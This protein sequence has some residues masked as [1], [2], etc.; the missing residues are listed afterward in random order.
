MHISSPICVFS[1]HIT[2]FGEIQS[3]YSLMCE[4]STYSQATA[5]F[6]LT[7]D[8]RGQSFKIGSNRGQPHSA[9]ILAFP[10]KS[11]ISPENAEKDADFNRNLR[12]SG[13]DWET[14]TLDLMRVKHAL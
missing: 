7:S 10:K 11:P 8:Q 1:K 12:L 3:A 13:G 4:L 2:G 6:A 5:G 9:P 14:R